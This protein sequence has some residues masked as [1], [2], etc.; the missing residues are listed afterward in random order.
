MS[1]DLSIRFLFCND[2]FS[3]HQLYPHLTRY[4][5]FLSVLTSWKVD[6]RD[7]PFLGVKRQAYLAFMYFTYRN[8]PIE[9][10]KPISGV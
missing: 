10:G 7:P 2:V 9:T 4:E 3:H 6:E 1:K 8:Y 5:A